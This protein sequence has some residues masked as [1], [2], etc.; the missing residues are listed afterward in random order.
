MQTAVQHHPFQQDNFLIYNRVATETIV[1]S[2][3]KFK[4]KISRQDYNNYSIDPLR[5]KSVFTEF[6]S[7]IYNLLNKKI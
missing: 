7:N 1:P 6:A 5:L 3:R 4:R 2:I